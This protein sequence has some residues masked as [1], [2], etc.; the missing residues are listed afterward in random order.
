MFELINYYEI[1]NGPIYSN[2]FPLRL[3]D[4]F[5][6]KILNIITLI[7]VNKNCKKYLIYF[8]LI[9]QI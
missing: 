4:K 6:P 3:D 5:G 1:K 2:I 7:I 9:K 8:I